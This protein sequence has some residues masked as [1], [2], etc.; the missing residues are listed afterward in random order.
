[1]QTLLDTA[2][3]G[4]SRWAR[5]AACAPSWRRCC[6]RRECRTSCGRAIGMSRT[7]STT[8]APGRGA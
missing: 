2:W 5:S 7:E 3:R 4:I 1:V 6:W 8:R